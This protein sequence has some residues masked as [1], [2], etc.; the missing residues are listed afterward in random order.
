MLVKHLIS[1]SAHSQ[2]NLKNRD[3]L[4]NRY[5]IKTF[6]ITYIKSQFR[7]KV[8]QTRSICEARVAS[9]RA[10]CPRA[11]PLASSGWVWNFDGPI[12]IFHLPTYLKL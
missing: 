4:T 2:N 6:N 1:S 3:Q 10:A 12:Q 5:Y 7:H 8:I 11:S 9:P